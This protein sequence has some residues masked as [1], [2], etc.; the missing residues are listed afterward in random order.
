MEGDLHLGHI[1]QKIRVKSAITYECSTYL[2][3][4]CGGIVHKSTGQLDDTN[5]PDDIIEKLMSPV[6]GTNRN[7]IDSWYT[8]YGLHLNYQ[9][10]VVETIQMN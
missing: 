3:G 2:F 6:C 10:T 7:I 5:G 9:F 8:S 4:T 1:P